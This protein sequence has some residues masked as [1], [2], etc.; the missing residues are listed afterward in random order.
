MQFLDVMRQG[1]RRYIEIAPEIPRATFLY[2]IHRAGGARCAAV[3][4]LQVDIQA[5]GVSQGL[6][7]HGQLVHVYISIIRHISKYRRNEPARQTW[8]DGG[9]VNQDQ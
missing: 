8:L 9:M 3:E 1:R 2:L 6:E 5:I 7:G 4:Q